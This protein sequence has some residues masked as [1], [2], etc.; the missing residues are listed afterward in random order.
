M[1][2]RRIAPPA[3]TA[4][5]GIAS[6]YF[7]LIGSAS[8]VIT[9]GIAAAV[10]VP[11]LAIRTVPANPYV[12]LIGA[13]SLTFGCFRTSR[14]LDR[15]RREGLSSAMVFLAAPLVGYATGASPSLP[16]A[17]A[18]LAGLGLLASIWRHLDASRSQ[19]AQSLHDNG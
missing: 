18:A 17:G 16:V 13:L 6:A 10:L 3:G 1:L 5:L 7:T 9:V 12:A 14:L 8:A 2:R 15:R 11:H 19:S 4:R